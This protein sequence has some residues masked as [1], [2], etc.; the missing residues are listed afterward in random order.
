MTCAHD[1]QTETHRYGQEPV[2]IVEILKICLK[3]ASTSLELSPLPLC[4]ESVRQCNNSTQYWSVI[5]GDFSKTLFLP[6]CITQPMSTTDDVFHQL[7][8]LIGSDPVRS[9]P[10]PSVQMSQFLDTHLLASLVSKSTVLIFVLPS[11]IKAKLDQRLRHLAN[12]RQLTNVTCKKK[13][14]LN[15]VVPKLRPAGQPGRQQGHFGSLAYSK[16]VS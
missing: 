2:C 12:N 5:I 7:W 16:T 4:P 8:D 14:T 3:T 10:V 9:G 13:P 11:L 6:A 1:T 15:Q